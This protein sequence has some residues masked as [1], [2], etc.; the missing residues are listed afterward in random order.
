[1]ANFRKGG[2]AALNTKSCDPCKEGDHHEGGEQRGI[3]AANE[4]IQW[5]EWDHD[6]LPDMRTLNCCMCY[7]TNK[8]RLHPRWESE[9]P[10]LGEKIE[11]AR[12]EFHRGI[13]NVTRDGQ[14][15]QHNE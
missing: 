8:D 15:W 4:S 6:Y 3:D 1:M 10:E 5:W 7:R 2:A 14:W 13:R 12:T 9:D 11:E